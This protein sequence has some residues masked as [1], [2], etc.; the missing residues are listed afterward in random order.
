MSTILD[1]QT[2]G[3]FLA[4]SDNANLLRLFGP[5]DASRGRRLIKDVVRVGKWKV[6]RNADGS[7]ILADFT[8]VTLSAIVD[9]FK[10][11]KS[12]GVSFNLGK[13]HGDATGAIR[14]DDL[15]APIDDVVF[16]G[17]TL[18]CSLYVNYADAVYLS[19]PAR[20][21]SIGLKKDYMDG[22]GNV[23]PISLLHVAVTDHP[24]VTDQKP[25]VALGETSTLDWMKLKSLINSLFKMFSWGPL[26]EAVTEETLLPALEAVVKSRVQEDD[27]ETANPQ[28]DSEM[29]D[30]KMTNEQFDALTLQ[31]T[32]LAN[33]LT[34][35]TKVI[36]TLTARVEASEAQVVTLSNK[37]AEV[38]TSNAKEQYA[39]RVTGMAQLGKIE[40]PVVNLLLE[41]GELNGWKLSALE[42]WEKLPSWSAVPQHSIAK[43]FASAG[44]PA[45]TG[46]EPDMTDEDVANVVKSF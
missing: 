31:L 21:V 20:L 13:G 30:A 44:A 42:N 39:Q 45:V 19:N 16:D 4:N 26:P 6:G 37:L 34:E 23:Y 28:G 15:I 2:E 7:A 9:N 1:I 46:V 5:A 14:A 10:L 35:S 17:K 24:V 22:H 33:S 29:A 43:T 36:S 25:F 27:E 8:P 32:T 11:A 12:R 38:T 40:S 3:A 41:V 18:W